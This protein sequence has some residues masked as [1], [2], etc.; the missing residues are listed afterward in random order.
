MIDRNRN[1]LN[2][3]DLLSALLRSPY[4]D[5]LTHHQLR[6]VYTL[7][8]KIWFSSY[9]FSYQSYLTK[10]ESTDNV[11]TIGIGL[12]LRLLISRVQKGY[13]KWV[14]RVTRP[15][16]TPVADRPAISREPFLKCMSDGRACRATSKIKFG[17]NVASWARTHSDSQAMCHHRLSF[18]RPPV[19]GLLGW[20]ATGHGILS[21]PARRP[22]APDSE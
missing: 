19:A 15:V 7:W 10:R 16:S 4:P 22:G 21:H 13:W 17:M 12:G 5:M 18:R 14:K 6:R 3:F 20:E 8:V 11:M 2:P 9:F 1:V